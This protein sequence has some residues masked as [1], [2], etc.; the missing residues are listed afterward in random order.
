MVDGL[1]GVGVRDQE[2]EPFHAGKD[3]SCRGLVLCVTVSDLFQDLSKAAQEL[4][5]VI[6]YLACALSIDTAAACVP[7]FDQ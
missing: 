4:G 3:V 7:A 6:D 5:C 2:G 1:G